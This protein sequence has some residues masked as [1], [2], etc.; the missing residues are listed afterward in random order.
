MQ[1]ADTKHLS[2][3]VKSIENK[4]LELDEEAMLARIIGPEITN[5]EKSLSFAQQI[6]RKQSLKCQLQCVL[7]TSNAAERLF[8]I[9][10][11]V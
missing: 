10:R 3:V 11:A 9:V 6:P 1:F 2:P 8:S 4:T 7:A 5:N